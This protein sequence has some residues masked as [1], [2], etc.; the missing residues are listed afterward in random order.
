[1]DGF[2]RLRHYAIISS[3]DK[4]HNIGCLRTASAHAGK[5]FVS[6]RVE[7]HDLTAVSWRLLILNGD[8]VRTNVLRDSSG[9]AFGY[10]GRSDRIEQRRLAMI[11]VPHDRNHWRTRHPLTGPLLSCSGFG[12]L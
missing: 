1:I 2:K 12:N 3:Y 4:N 10:A 9:F 11:N 7:E 6:R 5:R 8:F